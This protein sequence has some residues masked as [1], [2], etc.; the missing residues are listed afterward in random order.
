MPRRLLYIEQ[1][2]KIEL[3]IDIKMS[4]VECGRR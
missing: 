3:L 1:S 2:N 4:Y